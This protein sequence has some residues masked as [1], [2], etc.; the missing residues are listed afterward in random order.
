ML[1]PAGS[2]TA[3]TGSEI[4]YT[5]T[6]SNRGP[7]EAESV[8]LAEVIPANQM[9]LFSEST[10]GE[11][12]QQEGTVHCTLGSIASGA[13]VDITV[14]TKAIVSGD[15]ENMAVVVSSTLEQDPVSNRATVWVRGK[16]GG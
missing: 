5:I 8:R 11:C 3:L 9:I 6:V 7:N 2:K 1:L 15:S 10:Q 13:P 16:S 4:T 12:E 14:I